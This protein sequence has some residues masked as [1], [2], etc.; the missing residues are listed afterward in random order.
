[1]LQEG[2]ANG[3][4]NVKGG[5]MRVGYTSEKAMVRSIFLY[6]IFKNGF[7]LKPTKCCA[8]D[9]V[10]VFGIVHLHPLFASDRSIPDFSSV[11]AASGSKFL[12]VNR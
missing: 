7:C 10:S 3:S 5:A 2:N 9:V 4:Q 11:Q 1:M 8:I 12:A 6:R